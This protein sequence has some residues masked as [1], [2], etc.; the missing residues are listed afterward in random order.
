[1]ICRSLDYYM[2][3]MCFVV[4]IP[5]RCRTELLPPPFNLSYE[6][7][8]PFFIR[9]T[10]QSHPLN[11]N[12][13][14]KYILHRKDLPHRKPQIPHSAKGYTLLVTDLNSNVTLTLKTASTRT[15]RC[16]YDG[17]NAVS[18]VVPRQVQLVT[19]FK[20]FLY[21]P[22]D[23]G[24][25]QTPLCGQQATW[26]PGNGTSGL[27]VSY[28]LCGQASDELSL[29]QDNS[30]GP[31]QGCHLTGLKKE[32]IMGRVCILFRGTVEGRAL[33]QTFQRLPHYHIRTFPPNVSVSEQ[34][35]RLKISWQH[36]RACPNSWKYTVN[37]SECDRPTKAVTS[38]S[39][40]DHLLVPFNEACRYEIRVQPQLEASC[41]FAQ[42]EGSVLL[43]YNDGATPDHSV[44]VGC[45]VV[46]SLLSVLVVALCYCVRR[47]RNTFFKKIPVPPSSLKEMMSSLQ[48]SQL[49]VPER[50]KVDV[51]SVSPVSPDPLELNTLI[52]EV[53]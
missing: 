12:C 41:G 29:C 33:N 3:V 44:L 16:P 45:V 24:T 8:D 39:A 38:G 37:Y 43:V 19:D 40:M 1:M 46:P 26:T 48:Q 9:L 10:W 4:T 11:P 34:K 13:S 42:A 23:G 25:S 51:C 36:A 49:F 50:E 30:S 35:G 28:R 15:P 32:E 6:W 52:W 7:I 47:K 53:P 31:Q 18:I 20:F 14:L 21:P 5:Q 27:S 17:N 2:L 22:C